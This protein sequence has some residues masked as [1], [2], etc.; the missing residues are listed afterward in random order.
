MLV[1][2]HQPHYLPWTPYFAKIARS[3]RFVLLDDVQ[4]EKNGF[5]NRNKIKTPQGWAYLTIPVRRPTARPIREIEI[6]RATNWQVKHRR[7]LE[8]N[9]R[10][11]PFFEC[12]WP[13]LARLYERDWDRL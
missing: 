13:D 10:R 5:Q 9:Y 1:S 8:L 2:I 4:Y 12:Y 11:A 6:D 3:D 7:A